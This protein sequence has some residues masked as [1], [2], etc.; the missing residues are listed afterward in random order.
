ME[1]A[2]AARDRSGLSYLL[3]GLGKSLPPLDRSCW[4]E[5]PVVLGFQPLRLS[6]A[7]IIH[8]HLVPC[9]KGVSCQ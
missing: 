1:L 5:Y 3:T 2:G 6:A 7:F 9:R 8:G 4:H